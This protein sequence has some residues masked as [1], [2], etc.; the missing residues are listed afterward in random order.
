M[1]STRLKPVENAVEKIF[2]GCS[3]TAVYFFS[4]KRFQT[5][6]TAIEDFKTVCEL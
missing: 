6:L 4:I 2:N 1:K 5:F 3:I